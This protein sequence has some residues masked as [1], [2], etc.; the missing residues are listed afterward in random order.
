M[1]LTFRRLPER[2]NDFFTAI[3]A[4]DLYPV[5]LTIIDTTSAKTFSG[6][7]RYIGSIID[8]VLSPAQRV[9]LSLSYR[10]MRQSFSQETDVAAIN[11]FL[12]E[13]A[14]D[15][16]NKTLTVGVDTSAR[17]TWEASLSPYL[18]DLPFTHAGKGEQSAVKMKLAMRAAGAAHVLLVEEPENHLRPA[19]VL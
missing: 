6:T 7:D 8:Q 2:I 4:I 13:N 3:P 11:T 9:A 10:R 18:D 19:R 12:A 5:S 14:G 16:S 15:V 1:V 17:S